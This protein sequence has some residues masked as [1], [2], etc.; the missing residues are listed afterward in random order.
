MEAICT[1]GGGKAIV[2][3][4]G[5]ATGSNGIASPPAGGDPATMLFLG[6]SAVRRSIKNGEDNGEPCPD[7]RTGESG[8]DPWEPHPDNA[9]GTTQAESDKWDI[10]AKQGLGTDR[11]EWEGATAVMLTTRGHGCCTTE[12]GAEGE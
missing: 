6:T 1:T 5:M 3:G 2:D 12:R 9:P 10:S 11:G 8:R 7:R 4:T